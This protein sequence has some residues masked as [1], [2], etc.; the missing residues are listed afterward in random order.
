MAMSGPDSVQFG[1]NY[2]DMG[3]AAMLL[4]HSLWFPTDYAHQE[5]QVMRK[6]ALKVDP[7]ILKGVVKGTISRKGDIERTRAN[8]RDMEARH[9]AG[10]INEKFLADMRAEAE[11]QIATWEKEPHPVFV[12]FELGLKGRTAEDMRQMFVLGK[13]RHMML[14]KGY[15][16]EYAT[17]LTNLMYIYLEAK[18]EKR[19]RELTTRDVAVKQESINLTV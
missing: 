5:A 3:S 10:Q 16:R 17:H 12:K 14:D 15:E 8:I 7:C 11:R 4:S 18:E 13:T 6:A 2:N 9:L 1:S 19:R